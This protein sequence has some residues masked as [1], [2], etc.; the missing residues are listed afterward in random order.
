MSAVHLRRV[1][2]SRNMRGFYRLDIEPD[3][4]GGLLCS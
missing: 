1:D 3:L 2:P 4:F